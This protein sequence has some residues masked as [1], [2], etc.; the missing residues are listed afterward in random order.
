MLINFY[1]VNHH[2]LFCFLIYL[3]T[4][5]FFTLHKLALF[6][7]NH[8]MMACC[9][10]FYFCIRTQQERDIRHKIK[11]GEISGLPDDVL[12]NLPTSFF[13]S[14][15]GGGKGSGKSEWMPPKYDDGKTMIST[16]GIYCFNVLYLKGLVIGKQFHVKAYPIIFLTP[17]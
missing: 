14:A 7:N 11:K 9:N 3:I 6:Q 5:N 12:K 15:A 16:K 1:V 8:F 2:G 10:L 4:I 17:T 13:K